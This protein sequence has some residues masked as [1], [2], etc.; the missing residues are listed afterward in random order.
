M[1]DDGPWMTL[2]LSIA[3]RATP[4]PN[5]RVGAIVV[6]G[7]QLVALGWHERAGGA[8]AEAGALRAAAEGARGSTLYVTLEPCN[9]YGRTPPCVDAIV[10]ARV[11]RVVIG[12]RDPNPHV[13]GGGVARL[14]SHGIEVRV[15]VLAR[16]ARRLIEEWTRH[17]GGGREGRVRHSLER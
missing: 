3:R 16:E 13:T 4:D 2:A 8:H 11:D 15:G 10:A 7:R 9:H 17:V 6:R 1:R 14:R 5:P 12:C